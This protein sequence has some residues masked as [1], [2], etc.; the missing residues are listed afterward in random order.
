MKI[1][2]ATVLS[3]LALRPYQIR[4]GSGAQSDATVPTVWR[5]CLAYSGRS[6]VFEVELREPLKSIASKEYTLGLNGLVE[7]NMFSKPTVSAGDRIEI[8]LYEIGEKILVKE[9]LPNAFETSGVQPLWEAAQIR[10]R[11]DRRRCGRP[12]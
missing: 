8:N 12:N 10:E 11:I 9:E 3:I 6:T 7:F 4:N 1:S 5:M 2:E